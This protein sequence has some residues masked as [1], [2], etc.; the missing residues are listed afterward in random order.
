VTDGQLIY[1]TT[2]IHLLDGTR[3][4]MRDCTNVR[5]LHQFSVLSKHGSIFAILIAFDVIPR[6]V[7]PSSLFNFS[8]GQMHIY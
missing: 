3:E 5:A 8:I 4:L 1:R 2:T 7:L 6:V